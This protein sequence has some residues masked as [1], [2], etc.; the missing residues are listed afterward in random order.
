MSKN[1][2]TIILLLRNRQSANCSLFCPLFGVGNRH[3]VLVGHAISDI[4]SLLDMLFRTLC[5][6]WTCYFGHCVLVR[7][8]ISDTV[9]LLDMQFRTTLRGQMW[10]SCVYRK[11]TASRW[12]TML[13][14]LF[15]PLYQVTYCFGTSLQNSL[16][17]VLMFL[18]WCYVRWTKTMTSF[19]TFITFPWLA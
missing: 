19:D 8:A 9:S 5:P 15:Q 1:L 7:H 13:M 14:G 17:D 3:C 6:C 11:T 2:E 4:V 10:P 18:I 12:R 16:F